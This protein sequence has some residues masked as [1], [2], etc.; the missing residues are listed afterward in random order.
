MII[1]LFIYLF[2]FLFL[3]RNGS[4]VV[5]NASLLT[6][7]V[8]VLTFLSEKTKELIAHKATILYTVLDIHLLTHTFASGSV[9]SR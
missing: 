7:S 4:Q 5:S 1:Y 3:K 2:I 9:K 6:V 8:K